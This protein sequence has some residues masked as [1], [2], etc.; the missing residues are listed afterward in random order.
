MLLVKH[1]IMIGDFIIIF[2]RYVMMFITSQNGTTALEVKIEWIVK[3]FVSVLQ[4][5]QE[6]SVQFWTFVSDDEVK[7][8]L[9]S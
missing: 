1:L 4:K 8:I 3:M 6:L 5:Y 9:T 7:I 2:F